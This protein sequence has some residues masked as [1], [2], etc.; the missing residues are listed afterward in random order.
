MLLFHTRLEIWGDVNL[1]SMLV[2]FWLPFLVSFPS[3]PW[4]IHLFPFLLIWL[5]SAIFLYVLSRA[6]CAIEGVGRGGVVL[7]GWRRSIHGFAREIIQAH[8]LLCQHEAQFRVPV[9]LPV[10]K[11]TG[12]SSSSDNLWVQYR[13]RDCDQTIYQDPQ[14]HNGFINFCFHES[15]QVCEYD[16]D[17]PSQHSINW[18]KKQRIFFFWFCQWLS[19]LYFL[20]YFHQY[21]SAAIGS[22]L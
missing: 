20:I 8:D 6:Q 16:Q 10:P 3:N 9:P 15:T 12:E 13:N 18:N 14:V 19:C 22:Y 21:R 2:T 4:F 7:Y 17:F 1:L 11:A 5:F